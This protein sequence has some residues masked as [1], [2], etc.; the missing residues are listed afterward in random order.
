MCGVLDVC[1][2]SLEESYV[3]D[4]AVQAEERH[5][6][7]IDDQIACVK[8]ASPDV[9]RDVQGFTLVQMTSEVKSFKSNPP[10]IVRR[11]LEALYVVL[12]CRPP[13][14]G[15]AGTGMVGNRGLDSEKD[16]LKIQRMLSNGDFVHSVLS[17]DLS[18]LDASP[19]VAEFVA[20]RYFPSLQKDCISAID[21]KAAAR[22]ADT[23]A[24][25]STSVQPRAASASKSPFGAGAYAGGSSITGASPRSSRTHTG[26]FLKTPRS[27]RLPSLRQDDNGLDIAAV[28]HASRSCGVLVRWVAEVLRDFFMLRELYARRQT[29]SK[30]LDDA[31]RSCKAIEDTKMQSDPPQRTTSPLQ[32][33]QTLPSPPTVAPTRRSPRWAEEFSRSCF[34]GLTPRL[35]ARL[36][37]SSPEPCPQILGKVA[38]DAR[39]RN[40]GRSRQNTC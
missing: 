28:E 5:L 40:P 3:L 8:K 32:A 15:T 22:D 30:R 7:E 20:S 14:P 23:P 33:L 1:R 12:S 21:A 39:L 29:A 4:A 31:V 2:G 9:L 13:E 35:D 18:L 34:G 27:A 26:S 37:S 6:S 11:A 10:R 17:F 16:W 36:K 19:N 24:S 25:V 38:M